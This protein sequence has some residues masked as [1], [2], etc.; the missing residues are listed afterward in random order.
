MKV[1][2]IYVPTGE[3]KQGSFGVG[4]RR[5]NKSGGHWGVGFKK[6]GHF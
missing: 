6:I 4:F 2:G 3:R 1:T 5:K